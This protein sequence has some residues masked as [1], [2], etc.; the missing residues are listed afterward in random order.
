MHVDMTV[1]PDGSEVSLA[2]EG[3]TT[4]EDIAMAA[5]VICPEIFEF[6]DIRPEWNGGAL[7]VM[8]LI[9]L[10]H[11]NQILTKRFIE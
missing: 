5:K 4:G 6:I 9:S 11:I 7:G 10:F 1:S 8:Q 2:I 3:E